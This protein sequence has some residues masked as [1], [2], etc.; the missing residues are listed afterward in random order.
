MANWPRRMAETLDERPGL[1]ANI[2][3]PLWSEALLADTVACMTAEQQ[4][5][6]ARIT[7]KRIDPKRLTRNLPVLAKKP[8]KPS[9]QAWRHSLRLKA[10]EKEGGQG[11]PMDT[12]TRGR[13]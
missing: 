13:A 1:L 3:G 6:H 4:E 2:V 10:R 7:G 11:W 8:R 9:L 12:D 5:R